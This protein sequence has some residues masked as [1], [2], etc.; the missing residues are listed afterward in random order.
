MNIQ[1]LIRRK[2]VPAP[3]SEGDNIPWSNPDFSKRMLRE[4]FSQDHNAASRR[5]ATVER[6]VEWVHNNMLSGEPTKILDL[7]C[8]PGL[9]TSRLSRAGHECVGIDYSPVS[10]AYA[11]GQAKKDNLRCEYIHQDIRTADYGSG[12]R[13][14][15]L[16]YGEF[17]VF[18]PAD[19]RSILTK[20]DHALADDGL[21]LLEPHSFSAVKE[22]GEK[23]PAWGSGESG[24]FSDKPHLYL[25]E[26]FW[27]D[28]T[29]SATVRYYIIDAAS[30]DVTRYAQS[31]Q[32]YTDDEYRSVLEK[33]GFDDLEFYPSLG[34]STKESPGHLIAIVARKRASA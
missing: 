9:Y 10:I 16:I 20:A 12:F 31:F 21:L 11:A 6:H 22:I 30:G 14:V 25:T 15:M 32:S 2:P 29:G 23:A 3:W 7:G 27:D 19:A 28:S 17:N 8:G 13:L 18:S 4:H 5:L 33:C 34:G 1:D 26:N 24:L